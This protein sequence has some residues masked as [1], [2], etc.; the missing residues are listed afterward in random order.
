MPAAGVTLGTRRLIFYSVVIAVAIA[1][2]YASTRGLSFALPT[3][4]TPTTWQQM[5][6]Q[7]ASE[8]T[9][10]L[11]TLASALLGA[12]GLLLGNKF[13]GGGRPRHLWS[14]FACAIGA[15]V[16]LYYGYVVHMHLL[17]MI[18]YQAFDPTSAIFLDPSHYQFYA[19]L[20][21]AV[22]L[23]DFVFYNLGQDER[24]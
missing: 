9:R 21:A 15:G 16:S 23:V 20:I 17:G 22:F 6:V 12:L 7:I 5:G 8:A 11:I 3:R 13:A 10:L 1:A 2:G 4:E 14:A 18:G 19:L 24:T